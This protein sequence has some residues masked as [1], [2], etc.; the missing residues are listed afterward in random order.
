M[1]ANLMGELSGQAS[2]FPDSAATARIDRAEG[3]AAAAKMY[4]ADLQRESPDSMLSM[5]ER[6]ACVLES[7][8]DALAL[9]CPERETGPDRA[10]WS[11]M[12]RLSMRELVDAL[13]GLEQAAPGSLPAALLARAGAEAVRWDLVDR[14][15]PDAELWAWLGESFA[16]AHG[17]ETSRAAGDA[18]TVGREYLRA[19]AYHAAALDQQTL[20]TGFA[21][22]RLIDLSLPQLFLTRERTDAALYGVDVAQRGIPVRLARSTS[23]EGW[24]FV[25]VPAADMLSDVHGELTHG[26]RP[27]GLEKTDLAELRVAVTHLR[28]QWSARPPVRRFRRYSFNAHL[29]VVGG[30]DDVMGLLGD[31]SPE[32]VALGTGGWRIT[33]LSR[34]GVGATTSRSVESGVPAA[35]DLVAFCPEEGTQ[36]HIGLVRRVRLSKSGIEI[37]IATLSMNP[38]LA[39]VDDGRAV[40]ELFICEPVRR[41]EAIRLVGPVGSLEEDDPLFVMAKGSV[42]CKLRPLASALRGKSFDLRVYQAM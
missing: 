4:I 5:A 28:R 8:L 38:D 33:D 37:G 34:G 21:I 13:R 20:K 17:D 14:H 41:G 26:Q 27:F 15:A 6:A 31:G 19:I 11:S 23:F 10:H 22:A 7:F 9:L 40:H 39:R 3:I 29:S 16:A 35:G 24:Y 25:T 1:T 12:A 2:G 18:D 30:Y 36:W 32:A 42:V